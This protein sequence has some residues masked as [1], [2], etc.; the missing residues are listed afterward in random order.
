MVA[1]V[2]ATALV[3]LLVLDAKSARWKGF[4]MVGFYAVL[5]GAFWI[6]GDR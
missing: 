6:A 2:G 1:M 5:V 4:A 3:A